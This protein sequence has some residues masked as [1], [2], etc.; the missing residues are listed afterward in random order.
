MWLPSRLEE[1]SG[2]RPSKDRFEW[3]SSDSKDLS[4]LTDHMRLSYRTEVQPTPRQ[5]QA[6]LQHS[7]NARWAYN[8]GLTRKKE[9]WTIRKQAL[10]MRVSPANAPKVPSAIDLHRELNQLKK[11]SIESGGV[12]WMYKASK[13][14]PQEALRDLDLAFKHFFRRVKN[15]EK[16]GYPCF[17]SRNRGIVGFRLTG[18][19]S[20]NCKN[21]RLPVIGRIRIKPGDRGYL[22]R[23]RHSQI[24][25]TERGGRWFVS[26]VGPEIEEAKP[27]GGPE[28]GLDLGVIHLATFS[29][30]TI[31]KNPRALRVAERKIKKLQKEMS[32]KKKGSKNREKARARLARA[33]ARITNVRCDALHKATTKLTKSHGRIVME[34]LRVRNMTRSAKGRGK[35]AKAGLNRVVLDAAFGEFRR[36]LTYKG[37]LYGCE[38]VTVPSYYTSQRCAACGHIEAGNRKTQAEFKCLLCGHKANADLNA[39]KNILDAGSRSESKNACRED[40]RLGWSKPSERISMKQESAMVYPPSFRAPGT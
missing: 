18:A 5:L 32:R 23:G 20:V 24:S 21:V 28:I 19:I 39:A 8:W 3:G 17:K 22:P 40:V 10:D 15:G 6:L 16:P 36:L 33:Y 1:S 13:C 12:P 35:S 38:I 14:A 25:V 37:K 2:S 29:D 27:N 34:D 7:G 9:A 26:V 31:I 30:G 11:I 4:L